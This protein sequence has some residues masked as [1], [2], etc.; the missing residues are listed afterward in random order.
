MSYSIAAGNVGDGDGDF[1]IV[2]SGA[3]AGAITYSGSGENH[4]ATPTIALTV[5]ASD[6]HNGTAT[7]TVTVTVTD[8]EGE[9]PAA[10][11]AP[12]VSATAGS[13]TSI[14]VRWTAPENAGP[15][16]GDYDV[17]Y[18][19]ATSTSD[20]DWTDHP[21]TGA[22]GRRPSAASGGHGIPGAGAGAERRGRERL[23]GR[24]RPARPAPSTR[25]GGRPRRPSA[26]RP[27]PPSW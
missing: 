11:A 3:N 22:A 1:A 26:T 15:P 16:V 18:R 4:E 23:V 13:L 24:G 10:P 8:V 5:Q 14:D 17:E 2:A 12:E 25:R 6:N 19:L 7:V 21:H 9:A 20:G 27:R